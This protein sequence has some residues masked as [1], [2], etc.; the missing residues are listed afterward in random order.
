MVARGTRIAGWWVW[1]PC[2]GETYARVFT[3][4]EDAKEYCPLLASKVYYE[5]T[6]PLGPKHIM[7][8]SWNYDR[9][10]WS[11]DEP[12]ILTQD[13]VWAQFIKEQQEAV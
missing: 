12:L 7:R 10:E 5:R 3:S 1:W 9:N 2:S 11:N 6:P 8:V 4:E 13:E